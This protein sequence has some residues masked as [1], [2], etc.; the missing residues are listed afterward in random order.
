MDRLVIETTLSDLDGISMSEDQ[1]FSE[2]GSALLLSFKASNSSQIVAAFDA[3]KK[4]IGQHE[5]SFVICK[6]MVAGMFDLEIASDALDE[7]IRLSNKVI[8]DELLA[9]LE[10]DLEANKAVCLA[11]NVSDQLHWIDLNQVSIRECV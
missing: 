4:T 7:P 1:L 6:T 9:K 2:S 5:V 3:L 11:I 8:K 10:E